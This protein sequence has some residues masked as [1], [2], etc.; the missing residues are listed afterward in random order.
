MNRKNKPGAGR[1]PLDVIRMDITVTRKQ[2]EWLHSQPNASQII[3]N[4]VEDEM[5]QK[6]DYELD[7]LQEK[8]NDRMGDFQFSGDDWDFIFY[9]WPN[10][11]EHLRW[12]LTATREEICKWIN[13]GKA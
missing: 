13:A 3:R 8:A 10:Y 12:L 1:P 6:N 9:D 5:A 2:A 7:E 4:L 11:E